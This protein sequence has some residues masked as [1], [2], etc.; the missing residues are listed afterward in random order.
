MSFSFK[1]YIS[2]KESN[3]GILFLEEVV[4]GREIVNNPDWF[5]AFFT[6]NDASYKRN[7]EVKSTMSRGDLE[8]RLPHWTLFGNPPKPGMSLEDAE[9]A[10]IG[11][12]MANDRGDF[13]KLVGAGGGLQGQ[14]LG[15]E[16]IAATGKGIFGAMDPRLARVLTKPK[17]SPY[18]V[19]PAAVVKAMYP[20]I[21]QMRE[22]QGGGEWQGV[23]PDGSV[24]YDM[25]PS[26]GD[27]RVKTKAFVGT[28]PFFKFMLEKTLNKM[29]IDDKL[30]AMAK[31]M[32]SMA[33]PA[34][35]QKGIDLDEEGLKWILDIMD[36][37][38][39]GGAGQPDVPPTPGFVG[40]VSDPNAET[41]D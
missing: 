18:L 12:I 39:T 36:E 5:D 34:A 29:G 4:P 22:F 24:N 32:P 38:I 28:K 25:G 19:P 3:L 15:L 41:G 33:L 6:H 20:I 8:W 30:L 21:T 10:G 2:E 26:F 37:P 27:D 23:N 14:K 9:K 35:K 7:K 17:S 16:E 11:Y 1:Q 13:W 31:M 40:G